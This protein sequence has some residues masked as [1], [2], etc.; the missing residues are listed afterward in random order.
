M[1]NRD[2]FIEQYKPHQSRFIAGF[3]SA[4]NSGSTS[5]GHIQGTY[6]TINAIVTEQTTEQDPWYVVNL[7]GQNAKEVSLFDSIAV[8]GV[9]DADSAKDLALLQFGRMFDAMATDVTQTSAHGLM[10]HLNNADYR[11]TKQVFPWQLEQ[12]QN[13]LTSEKTDWQGIELKSHSNSASSLLLD[14]VKNDVDN[15]L[16]SSYDSLQS[17]L[18][19][20]DDIEISD[21]DSLYLNYK[22]LDKFMDMLH[23]AMNHAQGN[24]KVLEVETSKPFKRH[25]VVQVSVMYKLDDGQTITVFFQNPDSTPSKLASDDVLISWKYLLNKRDITGAIQPNQGEGIEIPILAGRL[26]KLADQNSGRFK[27]TQNKRIED[28][29]KLDDAQLRLASKKEQ[30]KQLTIELENLLSQLDLIMT[31]KNGNKPSNLSNDDP[32]NPS[33]SKTEEQ[34]MEE[35]RLADEAKAKDEAETKRIADE[36]KTKAEEE[37]KRLTDQAKNEANT[38]PYNDADTQFLNLIIQGQVS[39]LEVDMDE[40]IRIGEI[41]DTSE[42]YTKAL[43]VVELAIDEATA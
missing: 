41:D 25:N 26:M 23:L 10:H 39:P 21:F 22:F 17:V 43:N 20:I 11:Y 34:L 37:A 36:L 3:D 32:N 27:R 30:L 12:C 9:S 7:Q 28:Q 15:Q 8:L 13:I 6:R 16:V 5:I 4:V 31:A 40:F 18:N 38:S 35:Q 29:K 1:R 24:L 33:P 42:L 19:S 2:I 14:L